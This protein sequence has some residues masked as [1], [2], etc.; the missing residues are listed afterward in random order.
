MRKQSKAVNWCFKASRALDDL[1]ERA[2]EEGD[3]STKSDLVRDA[4]REKL[5][6]MGFSFQRKQGA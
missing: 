3:Y 2:V 1:L 5:A 4:V 6:I